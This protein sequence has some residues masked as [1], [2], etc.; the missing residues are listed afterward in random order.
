MLF[1]SN[2]DL[3]ALPMAATLMDFQRQNV[4]IFFRSVDQNM[5]PTQEQLDNLAAIETVIFIGYPSESLLNENN[6]LSV[7]RQGITA[8]PIWNEFGGEKAFLIDAGVFPGSCGS[9]VFIFNEG[10]YSSKGNLVVGNRLL[11]VGVLSQCI[12]EDDGDKRK[13]RKSVV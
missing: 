3:I 1:R 6:S 13:D 2:L 12:L 7:V 11:F 10:A 5:L 4:T 8:T 9:P